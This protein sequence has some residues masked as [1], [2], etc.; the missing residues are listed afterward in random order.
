MRAIPQFLARSVCLY[1]FAAGSLILLETRV[2]AAEEL[3]LSRETVTTGTQDRAAHFLPGALDAEMDSTTTAVGAG[4]GGYDGATKN[5][6]ASATAEVWVVPRLSFT[7]GFGSTTQPGDVRLRA[8]G[9]MRVMLLDQRHFGVNA[10]VGFLYR[11]DRFANEE[12]ML[13]WSALFS[14]RF[15]ATLAIANFVYAQD[16]EGDDREGEVRVLGL[17]DFGTRLHV[18]LDSRVRMSLGSSDPHRAQHSNPTLEFSAGPLLAYAAGR[19]S[20]MT[21][22]GISGQ[23]VD[24]LNTGVL[25]MGGFSAAF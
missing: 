21:E 3:E 1:S 22:A 8:Q 9:G 12:G 10:A 5:P 4:W 14:R 15:G 13:E 19:F 7:A 17:Q 25:V 18:G 11:Q 24:R 6:V 2:Q 20:L 23:K 16:G